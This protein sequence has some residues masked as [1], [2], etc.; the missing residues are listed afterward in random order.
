MRDDRIFHSVDNYHDFMKRSF[1]MI[2][3]NERFIRDLY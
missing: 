1:I 2:V 3:V